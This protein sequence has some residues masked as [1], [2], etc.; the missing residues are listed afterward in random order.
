VFKGFE[1]LFSKRTKMVA[2]PHCS[3]VIGPVNPVT[4][5]S[6]IAHKHGAL[7]VVDGVGYAPHGFLDIKALG[8]DIYLYN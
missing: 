6:E 2:F 7:S 5:I 8:A 4:K 1:G 3:N